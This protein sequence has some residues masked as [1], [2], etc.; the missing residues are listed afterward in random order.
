MIAPPFPRFAVHMLCPLLSR[1]ILAGLVLAGVLTPAVVG[2]EADLRRALVDNDLRPA[3]IVHPKVLESVLNTPRHEFVPRAQ[4]SLAYVDMSLPIG[5]QQ[6]ISSPFIVAFMTQALDPQPTDKVLEIGTGSGYQ[7][8]II[9][10]LV[11]EVYTIEIV[12]PLGKRAEQLL[13][14]L[15]YKNIHVRIGDGFKGW[16]EAAPFDKILV[17]CSPEEVPQPL[18]DQL[19]EG[20]QIVIPV[21]ERYQQTLYL[22]TKRNGALEKEALQPTIFVPMT[23]E[24]EALRERQPDTTRVTVLN[25]AFEDAPAGG[26]EFPGWYYERQVHRLAKDPESGGYFARFENSTSGRNSHLL[27]GF[28]L[29]GRRF[30]KLRIRGRLRLE[31]V[32][33]GPRDSSRP[34]LAISYFD[35][36]RD[37]VDE[38]WLG[39]W[40][41]TQDWFEAEGEVPVPAVAREAILRVGLFG[42]T[43]ILEADDIS[44]EGIAR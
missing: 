31:D 26:T 11:A 18:V 38:R 4:R 5:D 39:P 13:K 8:A 42:A 3:G 9:S 24:A 34:A 33:K 20:G 32:R 15:K 2:D 43:G 35:A 23:G 30:A 25:G 44:V 6:T 37:I 36:R 1:R 27:Q 14:R 22:M 41:G 28:A 40:E 7:A 21:G 12:A 16:P 29:D 19:I 10:P 17:T